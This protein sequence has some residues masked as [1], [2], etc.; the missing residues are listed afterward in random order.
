MSDRPFQK[1]VAGN[2]LTAGDMSGN[3]TTEPT[4]LNQKT[5]CSYSLTWAGTSPVGTV[6]VQVSN[7]YALS[8][9]GTLQAA[10]TWN[11]LTVNLAGSP[12]TTIPISG[13]TG[14]GFID[15]DATA[16]YAIRLIYT[17]ASGV[18][19]LNVTFCGKV[20]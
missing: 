10:G 1:P 19:A 11:T 9:N 16:A 12:V 18:G 13:N 4:I 7:D 6:S 3:L 20:M 14:T 15:I 17:F 5:M 2:V 8:P